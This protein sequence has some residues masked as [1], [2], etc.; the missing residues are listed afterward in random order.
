MELYDKTSSVKKRLCYFG[1]LPKDSFLTSSVLTSTLD[2]PFL[3]Q[4]II[5]SNG[6]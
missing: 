2:R 6:H 1:L 3:V 4:V 5:V